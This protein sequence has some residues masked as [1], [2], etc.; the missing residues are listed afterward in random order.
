MRIKIPKNE[1]NDHDIHLSVEFRHW[2]QSVWD[3]D[4]TLKMT[5]AQWNLSILRSVRFIWNHLRDQPQIKK[6][7]KPNEI[8]DIFVW[9][10][11][12][13]NDLV[14]SGFLGFGGSWG[15][16]SWFVSFQNECADDIEYCRRKQLVSILQTN[17]FTT[18]LHFTFF[19]K[20]QP[21]CLKNFWVIY[22]NTSLTS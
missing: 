13:F 22:R 3:S 21:F 17:H 19:K 14:W 1:D 2:I 18:I 8:C 6:W 7:W 16:L 9:A 4:F 11:T 10:E 12:C 20:P 5:E 15:A